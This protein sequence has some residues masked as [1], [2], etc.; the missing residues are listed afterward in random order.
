MNIEKIIIDQVKKNF[1]KIPNTLY[2]VII[3]QQIYSK[4][5]NVF[6]ETK[7]IGHSTKS[8]IIG[9]LPEMKEEEIKNLKKKIEKETNVSTYIR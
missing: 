5:T 3:V 1:T 4:K 2:K 6:F 8:I 7:K 9:E